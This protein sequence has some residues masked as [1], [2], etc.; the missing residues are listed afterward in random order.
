MILYHF[1]ETEPALRRVYYESRENDMRKH[2]YCMQNSGTVD[3]PILEFYTCSRNGDIRE[4]I[5]MPLDT[6]FD[7]LVKPS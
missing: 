6:S 5:R 7:K 2:L 1:C 3:E 4:R